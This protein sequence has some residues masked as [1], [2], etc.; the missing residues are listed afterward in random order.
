MAISRVYTKL[1]FLHFFFFKIII[2]LSEINEDY[3]IIK[4]WAKI[5][6]LH[7]FV[8]SDINFHQYKNQK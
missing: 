8:N 2:A 1:L 4:M 5:C 6:Q 3:Q 7:F